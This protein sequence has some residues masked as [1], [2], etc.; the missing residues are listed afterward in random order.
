MRETVSNLLGTYPLSRLREMWEIADNTDGHVDGIDQGDLTDAIRI[1]TTPTSE[2]QVIFPGVSHVGSSSIAFEV[3]E[4]QQ[5]T[6]VQKRNPA[7]R[8]HRTF[9]VKMIDQS[10]SMAEVNRRGY[11]AR[12]Q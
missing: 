9:S 1:A 12:H 10:G 4:G 7:E 8:Y 11:W 2:S 6:A 5:P 3:I